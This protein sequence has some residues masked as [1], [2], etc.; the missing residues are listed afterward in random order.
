MIWSCHRDSLESA[1]NTI[2]TLRPRERF[3]L[4]FG[5]DLTQSNIQDQGVAFNSS[6]NVLNI[7]RGAENFEFGVRGTIGRSCAK[8]ARIHP[9]PGVWDWNRIDD[10]LD[11]ADKNKIT[12]RIH[13][14]ISP[15]ASHWAKA[16]C[17][18]VMGF[19]LEVCIHF[20][21]NE[22][23]KSN[24]VFSIIDSVTSFSIF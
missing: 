11:F 3:E 9:K 13:G 2:I 17:S 19:S 16:A 4:E 22:T 23:G 7:F 20:F 10:Y 14:P 1:L 12:L 5:L 15:Q 6:I 18:S 8:Q 24:F 21:K